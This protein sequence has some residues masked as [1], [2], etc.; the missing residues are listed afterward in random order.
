[1]KILVDAR[2]L[3]GRPTG[4]G[5]YL[6]EVLR[7]WSM[8]RVAA[9]HEIVLCAHQVTA[10]ARELGFR[11]VETGHASGG[12]WWEQRTLPQ[13]IARERPAV[14]FS[15]GY[16]APLLARVPTAVTIHD[17]SFV[18]HPEWFTF[19][20]GA[21]RRLLT[22]A[23]ARRAAAV[24]TVSDF[25]AAEI[26]Q[27]FG[28]PMSRIHV[29][30]HGVPR[31]RPPAV[32]TAREPLVLFV[33]SVFNRRHVPDLMAALR[34]VLPH[35]RDARLVVVGENR[36]Q[37]R[38]D[39]SGTA[40]RLQIAHAV[41]LAEYVSEERLNELYARARV[42][43][44]VSDYEGFG[45]TPLEALASGVPPIVAD[46][47]VA[48][49]TCGRAAV[50]VKPGDVDALALAIRTLLTDDYARVRVFEAA[51][52]VLSR[53]SWDRAAEETLRVLERVAHR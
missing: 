5:R 25:S 28:V 7:R 35:V 41:E 2:E 51:P 38:E 48:H 21:R 45:L 37:P 40:A 29:V 14:L 22:R 31:A 4:V 52:A 43:A 46:T 30:R 26:S 50:F 39:L 33:G 12:T 24:L 3:G 19:R 11:I 36:T 17:V 13:V 10:G 9:S 32:P 1:V 53:Y 16:T 42:F 27:A 8:P 44:F 18:A 34:L 47:P 20:E 15:P 49:E 23:S 6:L